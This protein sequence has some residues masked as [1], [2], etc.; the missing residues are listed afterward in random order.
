VKKLKH[1]KYRNTG[2]LFELLVRQITA[3]V[4]DGKENSPANKLLKKHFSENTNLGKEQRLYQLLIEETT[5]DKSR[6]ESLLEVV[7]RNYKKLPKKDLTIARYELV[8]DIKE[9]YPISDLF[10]AKIKNY[11]TYASIFKLFES[12]NPEVYC[13]PTEIL[14]STDTIIKNLCSSQSDKN[15]LDEVNDYEKQNEDLRLIAYKLLV[16]NFNKKYSS[17]DNQQQKLLKNYINNIS[18][19]N[20]L[21]EYIDKQVPLIKSEI[22]KYSKLVDDNVVKIKLKEVVSQLDKTTEGKTVKD[23]QVS[24]LL[25]SYELIKELKQN[26]NYKS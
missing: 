3:D 10:R 14:E 20:S 2:I 26:A 6:A 19:T 16:D 12:H 15:E 11:K 18:N 23:S 9:S 24:T 25:M 1:S 5:S 8:R 13:E 21:R 4:L 7:T 22:N 17:L